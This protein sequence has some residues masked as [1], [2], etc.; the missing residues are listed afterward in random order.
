MPVDRPPLV[1][2]ASA[3]GVAPVLAR[4]DAWFGPDGAVATD[5]IE[6]AA[7][8]PGV[9]LSGPVIVEGVVET[10]VVPPGWTVRV[11]AVGSLVIEAAHS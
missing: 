10:T 4:R 3:S 2:D 7:F 11:D 8:R 1:D 6:R 9:T 5:V